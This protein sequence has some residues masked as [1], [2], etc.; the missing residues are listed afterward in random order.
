M[1]TAE[2]TN[3]YLSILREELVPAT[4]CTEPIALAYAAVRLRVLLGAAP[5]RIEADISGNII[6]NV[7]SVVVPNTGGRKGIAAAIAAGVVA[8]DA[9][10]ELQVIAD[11]PAARHA[12]IGAYADATPIDIRC[13]DTTRLLDIRLTGHAGAHTAAVQ[14]ANSHTN[15]VFESRDGEVL[16]Q[17]PFTD[18]PEDNLTDKSVLNVADIL[19]F[20]DAVDL[21]RVQDLLEA[22]LSC[23]LAIAQEGLAHPWGAQVGAILLAETPDPDAKT[24]AKAWA[25]AGSDAR[26]SGCEMPVIINSGSGN[27]GITVSVPLVVYARAQQLPDERLYRALALSNLLAI[28]QRSGI[29]CLSAY[30][31][32]INAGVAAACGVVYLQGGTLDDIAHTL[33]NG[34]A[35]VSGVI[36]DGAKPSCAAKIAVGIDAGLMGFEMYRHNQQFYRGEGI[37]KHNADATVA[38]V[39]R[40]GRYGMRETDREILHIM[41][42][43]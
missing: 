10:R 32:A 14:I 5:A 15:I 39:A 2:T 6:K 17:K 40:L 42:D 13:A 1:L 23:N 37:V 29:G 22:Q 8:G 41:I 19:E 43:E 12:A 11:V 4:G 18:S 25:A 28:Y 36:C 20:A 24:E 35:I 3:A 16:L 9:A 34:L 26:M 27:Q 7:K 33:V 38:A 30:C 31:G 21:A